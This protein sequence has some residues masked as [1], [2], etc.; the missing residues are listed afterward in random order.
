[1]PACAS[2]CSQLACGLMWAKVSRPEAAAA[3]AAPWGEKRRPPLG[4]LLPQKLCNGPTPALH[5]VCGA[6]AEQQVSTHSWPPWN[7]DSSQ[8]CTVA[9]TILLHV[10]KALGLGLRHTWL[11]LTLRPHSNLRLTTTGWAA[12]SS[13]CL[14]VST[15]ADQQIERAL[16]VRQGAHEHSQSGLRNEGARSPTGTLAPASSLASATTASSHWSSTDGLPYLHRTRQRLRSPVVPLANGTQ[17]LSMRFQA[18]GS[19]IQQHAHQ[20]RPGLLPSTDATDPKGLWYTPSSVS[21][22]APG[23]CSQTVRAS[24]MAG[25]VLHNPLQQLYMRC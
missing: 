4:A 7:C 5:R 2:F 25:Q 24:C 15:G 17:H 19:E 12:V 23:P 10:R 20:G 9:A 8:V 11:T 18:R 21:C 22:R 1:M 6:L 14:A 13:L 16:Y 3:P